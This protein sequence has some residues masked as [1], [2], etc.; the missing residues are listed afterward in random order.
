MEK[1]PVCKS[2]IA[3]LC[4]VLLATFACADEKADL[5]K[6]SQNPVG[7]IISLPSNIGTMMVWPMIR[8]EMHW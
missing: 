2:A 1:I 4:I 5:A 3:A 7:N 6:K 8:V